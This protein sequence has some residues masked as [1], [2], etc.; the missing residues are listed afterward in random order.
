[1][2]NWRITKPQT[3]EQYTKMYDLR[4]RVLREPWG[5]PRGS[6][7]ASDDQLSTHAIVI[8]QNE[9][10]IATCRAHQSGENQ[11]QLRFMAVCPDYQ[12]QG[13]GKAILKYI[14]TIAIE[15]FKPTHQIILHAREPAVNFY[16][17]HGYVVI[18]KSYLLF[19]EIQHYLMM[20]TLI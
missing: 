9:E 5:E 11:I 14:E 1:M 8:N 16:K 10:V 12:K 19:G 15:T 6:E 13:L 3:E 18:S 2:A 4:F 7:K 20:K 17:S